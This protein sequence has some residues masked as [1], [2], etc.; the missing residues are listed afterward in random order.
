MGER[1]RGLAEA[2]VV[3]EDARQLLLAQ[4]LQPGQAFL[5]VVAQFEAQAGRRSDAADALGGAQLVGQRQDVALP[6][7]LPAA[8]VVELGQARGVEARNAQGVAAG[9]AVEKVDQRRRQRLDAAGRDADALAQ[10]GLQF[11]RF[12]VGDGVDQ[13]AVEPAGVAAEQRGEQRRQGHALAVDDDAHVE[14]EPAVVGFDEVGFPAVDGQQV[15]AKI[16]RILDLPAG[17]AQG[18]AAVLHEG[19]PCPFAGQAENA[20]RRAAEGVERMRRNLLEAGCGQRLQS[21]D[22]R[23]RTPFQLDRL[24]FRQGDEFVVFIGPDIDIGVAEQRPGDIEEVAGKTAAVA[25][26]RPVAVGREGVQHQDRPQRHVDHAQADRGVLGWLGQFGGEF[27]QGLGDDRRF[28]RRQRRQAE[29]AVDDRRIPGHLE[30]AGL[31]FREVDIPRRLDRDDQRRRRLGDQQRPLQAARVD[32]PADRGRARLARPE[33]QIVAAVRVETAALHQ[34]LE[35]LGAVLRPE[36]E[37]AQ[38]GFVQAVGP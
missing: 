24:A 31:A 16:F 32:A 25:A 38:A 19:G 13:H 28:L 33:R 26:P 34:A 11:D 3:G 20:F 8:G 1:L 14:V 35:H 23:V 36:A 21:R 30:R 27:G 9:E 15:M 29:Q 17:G 4:E 5:L 6:L 2:H 10:R 22:F 7:E 18:L 37:G 12:V